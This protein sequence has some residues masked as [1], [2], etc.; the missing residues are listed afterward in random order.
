M[1]DYFQERGINAKA[2]S[3]STPAP[4]RE[5]AF[6][7]LREG[8]VQA[9]FSVNLFNE[10]LDIPDVD[11]LLFLRPTESVTVYLQQFGRGLRRTPTKEILTFSTSSASIVASTVLKNV[12][13]R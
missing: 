12:S 2:L 8:G 7:A 10:G 13:M 5:A 9:L 4:E 11:T 1:A 6:N 3:G